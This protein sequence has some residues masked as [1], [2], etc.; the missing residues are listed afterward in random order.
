MAI[1]IYPRWPSTVILDSANIAIRSIDPENPGLEQVLIQMLRPVESHSGARENII[2]DSRGPTLP[3]C[4]SWNRDA[5]GVER[6]ETWG[7]YVSPHHRTRGPRERRKLLM[8][9]WSGVR[10]EPQPKIDFMHILGQKEDTWNTI[11]IIFERRWGPPNVA[12]PGK[13]SPLPPLD[14]PADAY[15]IQ[16]NTI[17]SNLYCKTQLTERMNWV[18]M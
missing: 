9:W 11:F 12:G 13:T 4:M 3:F 8:E 2:A 14:G 17:Q 10:G 16:S 6:E 15:P 18:I 1:F 7:G 5:E